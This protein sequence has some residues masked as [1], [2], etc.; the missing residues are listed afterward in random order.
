MDG[1]VVDKGGD[2]RFAP[3]DVNVRVGELV[4]FEP[5]YDL[6]TELAG[7]EQSR[8]VIGARVFGASCGKNNDVGNLRETP[9]K[10]ESTG[11]RRT[12]VI[13]PLPLIL[14]RQHTIEIQADS[15]ADRGGRFFLFNRNFAQFRTPFRPLCFWQF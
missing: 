10:I 12:D 2:A 15:R 8:I 6:D 1:P 9:G 5:L 11:N 13:E 14:G 3:T 4:L 7:R